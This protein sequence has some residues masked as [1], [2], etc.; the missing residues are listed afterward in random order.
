MKTDDFSELSALHKT[1][2]AAKFATFPDPQYA[3]ITASPIL[4]GLS[5]GIY[6]EM[7]RLQEKKMK[8]MGKD[9]QDWRR[10]KDAHGFRGQ[11]RIAV[12]VARRSGFFK[13]MSRE[14]RIKSAKCYLSPFTCTESELEQ[15]VD[16]VERGSGTQSIEKLF[17]ENDFTGARL[18][19]CSYTYLS[20]GGDAHLVLGMKNGTS[21]DIFFGGVQTFRESKDGRN[22]LSDSIPE[23]K[24]HTVSSGSLQK[25]DASF[26]S[27]MCK[28]RIVIESDTVDY[29]L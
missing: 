16:E 29:W 26:V 28:E 13:S 12:M 27:D 18:Y 19:D 5:N 8:G 17:A 20:T 2:L 6:D 10:I 22:D 3:E 9:W 23:L 14:D 4:A 25:L 1:I 21:C 15:F 7:C 24:K 11:W